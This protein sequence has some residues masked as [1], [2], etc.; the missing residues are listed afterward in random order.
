MRRNLVLA[1]ALALA[2]IAGHANAQTCIGANDAG[3]CP[4]TALTTNPI[5]TNQTWTTGPAN[6]AQG[7]F[8]CPI[9][10]NEPVFVKSGGTLNI[11]PGCVVRGQP[12]QAAVAMGVTA[13]TPGA[14]IVSQTGK[15]NAVG[16]PTNPIIFTTAAV[17]AVAPVGV[18]DNVDGNASFL[19][20]APSAAATFLDGT[21][22]T[23]PLSP[24]NPLG[25]QNSVLW[26]G[27]VLLGNAPTNLSNFQGQGHGL[28]TIEGM[29]V[30]GFAPADVRYGGVN[31]HDSSGRFSYV[32]IRHGG[33]EIGDSNELNCLSMGG[34]GDG[35]E[36][37][38][39]DC[40]VNFDD[41]FEWFGGTV[42]TNHLMASYV[43]DDMFDLDQGFTGVGQF[44][45][46]IQGNFNQNS[47]S[48]YGS[49]SGDK[50]AEWDGDDYRFSTATALGV[51]V[52]CSTR[53]QVGGTTSPAPA[54]ENTPWP[55]SNP[56]VYNMTLIGAGGA[57]SDGFVNP[58]AS[59]LTPAALAGKRGVDM[60]NGF[61]GRL[62]NGLVVN[63]ATGPG[64]DVRV[65]DGACPGFDATTNATAGLVAVGTSSFDDVAAMG[66]S[67]TTA[68]TNGNNLRV[69]LGAPNNA[70]SLNCVNDLLFAGLTSEDTLIVPTGNVAGKLDATLLA[71]P[72]DPDPTFGACGANGVPPRHPGLDRAATYRG[73][74]EPGADNW[75]TGW[76]ALNR[77]GLLAN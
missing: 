51:N 1:A 29:T 60:R 50:G 68:L 9:V 19:D 64:L 65:G 67:A 62:F 74:F 12:R 70:N 69:G 20:P 14:L 13:G 55:L 27:V 31:P 2:G 36:V 71:Q 23:A 32:S 40:Y 26:G 37:S 11:A 42:D 73:A 46:G 15:I 35:T 17:D 3:E 52:N 22:L 77:G 38:Y 4:A 63:T 18:A 58:A 10:L 43:G 8:S 33:D 16:T 66:A 47:G 28:A 54:V 61:A 39:V 72:I 45:F 7:I 75:T 57:T 24:L 48:L 56:A 6:P 49:A 44:W 34:L 53:F 59:P 76:T 30:P 25:V 21:P 41:A 5:V